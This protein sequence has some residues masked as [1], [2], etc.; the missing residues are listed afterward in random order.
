MESRKRFK[1]HGRWKLKLL[2]EALSFAGQAYQ[3][4]CGVWYFLQRLRPRIK[5]G[6]QNTGIR[7]DPEFQ[8]KIRRL[9]AILGYCRRHQPR[10]GIVSVDAFSFYRQPLVSRAWWKMGRREQPPV[11]RSKKSNTHGRIVN[12]SD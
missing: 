8:R 3:S 6:R 2:R 7:W 12:E 4:L 1:E 10:A 9:R 5:R 11:K